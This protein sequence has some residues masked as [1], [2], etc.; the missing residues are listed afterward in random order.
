MNPSKHLKT[1]LDLDGA[2]NSLPALLHAS[3]GLGTHDTTTPVT[4]GI[5]VVLLEVAVV[6]SADELLEL[7]LVLGADLS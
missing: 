4:R 3:V 6:D 7:V 5:L 1:R 2:L